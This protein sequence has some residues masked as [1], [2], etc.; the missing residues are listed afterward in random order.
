MSGVCYFRPMRK[1]AEL[2]ENECDTYHYPVKC[3]VCGSATRTM[4][5][6]WD[7]GYHDAINFCGVC[8]AEFTNPLPPKYNIE[9][10]KQNPN[11]LA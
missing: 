6:V 1:R 9:Y 4:T 3:S 7:C 10:M 8:G 5:C 2:V 11:P